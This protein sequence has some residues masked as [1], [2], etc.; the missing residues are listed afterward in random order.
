MAPNLVL[1]STDYKVIG[2]RPIRHD[3]ADKV[4]GKALYGA[5]VQLPNLAFGKV[6]RSPHAHARIKSID[7]SK[8]E[9]NPAVLAVATAWDLAPVPDQLADVGE[10]SVLSLKY[11]SNNVLAGE[12]VLYKGHPIAA[13]AAKNPHVAEEALALIEV[14]YEVLPAVTNAEDAMK[15]DAP[16][17]QEHMT[18]ASFDGRFPKQTNI[19]SYQQLELGDVGQGF[20]EA[21][22]VVER[23][24]RTTTVHQGYIE[25]QSATAWWAPGERLTIWCSSQNPFGIR[26]NTAHILGIPSSQ[27]KVVPME[28]GGGF[29]GKLSCYLEPVAA[30][31]SKKA[32]RPVK[33]SMSRTEV[34]E[35]TGPTSG[36][37]MSVKMGGSRDGRITA[38]QAYLVFEAGAY[39]GSPIGGATSS[40][41]TPYDIPNLLVDGF[42]VVDNKPKTA[43]YRAPGAPM[44]C[45]AVESLID[46][47]S[48]KL[49]MDPMD[50][51]LR[52]AAA[53]GTRRADGTP[54]PRIGCI[55]VME[56]VRSHP[57]YIAPLEGKNPGRG[58]AVGFWRNNAGPSCVVANVNP[59]G[60]VMLA[61]GSVDIGGSRTAVA[62]QL[63]EVLSIPVEDVHPTVADTD[64]IGYTSQTAGS[65]VAF[66]TGWAA[67]EAAQD[68]RRQ[69][70]ERAALLWEAYPDQVQER[71]GVF[72]HE[73][74]PELRLNFKQ[75]ASRLNETGG[76]VVGRSNLDP[77]G[78]GGSCT[79]TLVDVDVD[80]ETGKVQ[81]LRCTA[82]QD[83]GK[84][85]HPS[86][87]EGQMQ[88]GTVQGIGWALNEGYCMSDQG[89]LLNASFLDYRMPTSLDLPMIDTVIVEVPNP[90]H[91]FGVRG[92]GEAPIVPPLAA[93]ANAI[94]HAAG[95]RMNRLPMNPGAVLEAIQGESGAPAGGA[96]PGQAL[97]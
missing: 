96:E 40:M 38:A 75:L 16:I 43:A 10:G 56:A 37:W 34:L 79:A 55:E 7:T 36:S 14:D 89:E 66:K 85:I 77:W 65:S 42:D 91:P 52:N 88:G 5:D 81:V 73:A 68:I 97:C 64:T 6:L 47:L 82:F 76:P 24:Y 90:G 33:M 29:G 84:A 4:T 49:G 51:R 3:G 62:Q 18:T 35:A 86:Y 2:T 26:D 39:P 21:D 93:M 70:I 45:F 80:P 41:F 9:A 83:A 32:G 8:A 11:L 59:D 46:E 95:V 48:E 1:S 31:L 19:A 53:E 87:V 69:M 13:V 27:I 44:G 28:I 63:A 78:V 20:R 12:K 17:L 25:P 22:V 15:P 72:Q 23:E 57:H 50:F 54:N 60:A 67:Y 94:H 92:V 61:V 74:D 58:V 30:V 71:D